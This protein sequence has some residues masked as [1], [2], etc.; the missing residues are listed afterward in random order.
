[1]KVNVQNFITSSATFAPVE[2][3][4]SMAGKFFWPECCK[5]TDTVF[6]KHIYIKC[7]V[8]L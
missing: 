1:M 2:R 5:L 8:S 4:F 6:E 3:L 7:N